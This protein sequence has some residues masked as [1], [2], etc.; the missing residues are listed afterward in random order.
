M[1]EHFDYFDKLQGLKEQEL[2]DEITM[3]NTKFYALV[4][5]T[6]IRQQIGHMLDMAR[7]QL[8]ITVA[9]RSQPKEPEVLEIGE[10]EEKVETP[11]Y[12]EK[13]LI[14]YFKRFYSGDKSS[15]KENI[16]K[17]I[18]GSRKT[19]PTFI[20]PVDRPIKRSGG[21]PDVGNI[22]VFGAKK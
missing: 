19:T 3:L 17:P 13:E 4:K 18:T 11:D 2:R 8:I 22:P 6:P 12:T 14:T 1:T 15:Q 16:E 7:D 21:K 9:Q 5:D 20:T 10:I